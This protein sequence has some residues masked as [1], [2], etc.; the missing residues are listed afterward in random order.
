MQRKNDVRY[1]PEPMI[2][3]L[4]LSKRAYAELQK[5]W[6]GHF[7][8]E[9][10]PLINEDI[11]EPLYSDKKS[12]PGIPVNVLIGIMLIADMQKCTFDQIAK[13]TA[14]DFEIKYALYLDDADF[15]FETCCKTIQRF[16]HK[17]VVYEEEHGVDLIHECF[18]DLTNKQKQIMGI[19]G[20]LM[21]I[22]SLMIDDN[23]RTMN[24]LDLLYTVIKNE[25]LEL[26]GVVKKRPKQ[27]YTK[28]PFRNS[29]MEGQLSFDADGTITE[30]PES[31][32]GSDTASEDDE[33]SALKMRSLNDV[34]ELIANSSCPD[35]PESLYHFVLRDDR[36]AFLYHDQEHDDESKTA[37]LLRDAKT[38]VDF[39]G[40][41]FKD[42]DVYQKMM[43]VLDEQCVRKE[44][45]SFEPRKAGD[46]RLNSTICQN[47]YAPEST[48][49]KKDGRSYRGDK[50]TIVEQ[51]SAAGDSLIA[52]YQYGS[53]IESDDAQGAA[54]IERM[55]QSGQTQDSL[56]VG[57]G[58]FNGTKTQEALKDSGMTV[59]N[60]N[61]SGKKAPDVHADH[62][63]DPET[64]E[65]IEC[66]GGQTPIKS[67]R[68]ANG[69]TRSVM[70]LG[71]CIG[72]P[73]YQE[74]FSH[75]QRKKHQEALA[76]GLK[77][78]KTSA[79]I[80]VDMLTSMKSKQRA[81]QNRQRSSEF[82]CE[83]SCYR[84][85]I[86][87]AIS[88]LR[89]CLL[90]DY[91]PPNGRSYRKLFFGLTVMASNVMHQIRY[92]QRKSAEKVCPSAGNYCTLQME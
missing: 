38:L 89:R 1:K 88:Y 80:H 85:G 46:P 74:C 86:E 69:Q 54:I 52:E 33:V 64:G 35:L 56:L 4:C 2:Y 34:K 61:L 29:Q 53:N 22:D 9:V 15:D 6:A 70:C 57:D 59:Q 16:L 36:N 39:C 60:T 92:H 73:H 87:A 44:D 68:Y 31:S 76:K 41:R 12:R 43:R 45:G 50:S 75:K 24:R 23:V 66:A 25:V 17:C 19:N 67:K 79:D 71:V 55:K 82:F 5:G 28:I 51:S 37:A 14:F 26:T 83:C 42:N 10:M 84:N 18:L 32:D 62:K 63:L 49:C 7:R 91:M 48:Y 72:C 65:L 77:K 3:Q 58:L 81:Q 20:Q 11:F 13:R 40:D 90:I 30:E 8:R 47:P 27:T 78:G 21:R